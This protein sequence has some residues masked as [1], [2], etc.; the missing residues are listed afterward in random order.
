MRLPLEAIPRII[1]QVEQL[2]AVL[3]ARLNSPATV[4]AVS[5]SEA[6]MDGDLLRVDQAAQ[7]L[8]VSV[9]WLYRHYKQL[10]FA[11]RLSRKTLRFSEAGLRQW[12]ALRRS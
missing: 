8:G 2:R 9:R 12:L 11:R 6:S 7:I 10:P 4:Q 1:G 3:W 5:E